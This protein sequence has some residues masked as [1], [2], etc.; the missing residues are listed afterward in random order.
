MVNN[1]NLPEANKLAIY[2]HGQGYELG[3]T[4]NKSS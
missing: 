4:K 1:P 2:K 3:T